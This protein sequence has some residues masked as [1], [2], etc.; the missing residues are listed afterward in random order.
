MSYF[1]DQRLAW[2]L[3]VGERLSEVW[4]ADMSVSMRPD[5]PK[6]IALTDVIHNLERALVVSPRLS[7]FLRAQSLPALEPLPV[8]VLDHKGRV[9]SNDYA[10]VNCCLVLDCVDQSQSEYE[11][12]GLETPSMVMSRLVLNTE[13]LEGDTRLIRPQFVPGRTLFR[14]DL[15]EMLNR[16][17]FTGLAFTRKIF[18]DRKVYRAPR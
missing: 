18:G 7:A 14:A 9:A 2:A 3:S 8:T 10:V 4:P 11:W 12:D 13:A 16:E 1:S 17:K 15:R 5:R 6:D